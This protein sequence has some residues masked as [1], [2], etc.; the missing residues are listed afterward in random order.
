MSVRVRVEREPD[1]QRSGPAGEWGSPRVAGPLR[2]ESWWSPKAPGPPKMRV[3]ACPGLSTGGFRR[4]PD[5]K[6]GP[7]K[8]GIS[9]VKHTQAKHTHNPNTHGPW[10]SACL[11]N[12][13]KFKRNGSKHT[14]DK[15]TNHAKIHHPKNTKPTKKT[16]RHKSLKKKTKNQRTPNKKG[17]NHE[18]QIKN[19]DN[20]SRKIHKHKSLPKAPLPGWG[21]PPVW[22]KLSRSPLP[23]VGTIKEKG[24][25][26]GE[27]P[28][29]KVP[30]LS[31][32]VQLERSLLPPS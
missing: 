12:Q 27:R 8:R 28:W 23:V 25:E 19:L 29:L 9:G 26:K 22:L 17:H 18:S 7:T 4:P 21:R 13:S 1:R 20:K 30:S 5:P 15:K 24:V 10:E 31:L 2:V 14:K 6:R 3:W 32:I 16:S 11:R